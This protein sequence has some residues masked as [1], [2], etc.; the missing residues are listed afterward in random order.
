[1][2]K[3]DKY[4]LGDEIISYNLL[5]PSSSLAE[6]NLAICSHL[7]VRCVTPSSP[8]P[9]RKKTRNILIVDSD[10]TV[11]KMLALMC[12]TF[13]GEAS[14]VSSL[15]E[16]YAVLQ[17]NTFDLVITDYPLPPDNGLMLVCKMRQLGLETPAIVMTDDPSISKFLQP[18]ILNIAKV[19]I[20]PFTRATLKTAVEEC[21]R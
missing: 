8:E 21:I 4:Q 3:R 6:V 14:T 1:M 9:K 13:E 10:Q 5:L 12:A 11:A 19:L 17:Q 15:E 18:G 16:A 2:N 7:I 20:K